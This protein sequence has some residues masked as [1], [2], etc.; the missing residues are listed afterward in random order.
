MVSP[1]LAPGKYILKLDPIGIVLGLTLSKSEM[2]VSV[3]EACVLD[4]CHTE[5]C[6]RWYRRLSYEMRVLRCVICT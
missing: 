4:D 1:D 2:K 3:N 6:N 5:E